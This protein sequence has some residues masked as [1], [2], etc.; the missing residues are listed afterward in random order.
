VN[1]KDQVSLRRNKLFLL[2][3]TLLSLQ[4]VRSLQI[5]FHYSL[6]FLYSQH[7]FP[8]PFMSLWGRFRPRPNGTYRPPLL[9]APSTKEGR[10]WSMIDYSE[11]QCSKDYM[12][13]Q[14]RKPQ[15]DSSKCPGKWREHR[16]YRDCPRTCVHG[17]HH[18]QMT[19]GSPSSWSHLPQMGP[20]YADASGSHLVWHLEK[21]LHISA[22]TLSDSSTVR[23]TSITLVT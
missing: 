17:F 9:A 16:Y 7:C 14:P 8:R 19:A 13:L 3:N 2:S 11:Y 6:S 18:G 10:E 23:I 1:R 21:K 15:S 5:L 22:L 12:L 20:C 4:S